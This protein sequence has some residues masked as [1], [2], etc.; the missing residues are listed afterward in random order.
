M[1]S[2][3]RFGGSAGKIS[4]TVQV[5]P[6]GMLFTGYDPLAVRLKDAVRGG[7]PH[8]TIIGN[9]VLAGSGIVVLLV[10]VFVTFRPSA[11]RRASAPR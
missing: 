7:G 2:G 8:V 10:T 4:A 1:S 9:S 3:Q 11:R 5:L 6:N